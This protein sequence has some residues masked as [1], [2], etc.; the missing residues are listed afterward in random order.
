MSEE[1]A[2]FSGT[3]YDSRWNG[4]LDA[5]L[6]QEPKWLMD[7][8]KQA[9][10]QSIPIIRRE[11]EFFLRWLLAV[12]Q[13]RNLLEVGTAVGYS[14]IYMLH[15]APEDASMVTIEY[16]GDRFA[17]ARDNFRQSGFEERITLLEG[18]AAT[19]LP[20]MEGS[21]DWIFLDA[22]KAQYIVLLPQLLRLLAPK[23]ILI[24]DNIIQEMD[25]LQSR[26]AVRRRDRTIH[27]RMREFL[28]AI[29]HDPM[30]ETDMLQVGDGIAVSVKRS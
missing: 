11:M 2:L 14:A 30:L 16:D 7:L 1:G 21:F 26:F 20:D 23:G 4:F 25:T 9:Q 29:T 8:R 18:D 6:R 5:S 19:I 22:A 13:P 17:K 27:K 12:K 28:H 15:Y 3:S 24:T 10:S